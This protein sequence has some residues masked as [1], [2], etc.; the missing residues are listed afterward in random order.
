[1]P[2]ESGPPNLG[3]VHLT[4]MAFATLMVVIVALAL[5]TT[6]NRVEIQQTAASEA[7]PGV[8]GLAHPHVQLQRS[9]TE[10]TRDPRDR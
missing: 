9:P 10:P 3:N 8:T 1:M 4:I 2:R 5:I 7:P 6:L